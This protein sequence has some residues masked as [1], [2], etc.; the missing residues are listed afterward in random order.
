LGYA[1]KPDNLG[2]SLAGH[3]GPS[4]N[5]G[6]VDLWKNVGPIWGN[7]MNIVPQNPVFYSNLYYVFFLY[8]VIKFV[9]WGIVYPF[10][11]QPKSQIFD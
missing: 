9:I 4:R 7:S 1:H 5:R 6:S 10:L 3:Q 2:Q 11:D 8:T